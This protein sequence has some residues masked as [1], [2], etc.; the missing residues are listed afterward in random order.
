MAAD[1]KDLQAAFSET[2]KRRKNVE[3]Q[4]TEAQAHITEDSAKLQDL[5][6]QNDKMKV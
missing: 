4:F 6:A 2:D 3:A 5:S 1:L